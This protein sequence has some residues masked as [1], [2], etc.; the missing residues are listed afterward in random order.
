MMPG[1][2]TASDPRS[3]YT[4][5]RGCAYE[6]V[7]RGE[8]RDR[9]ISY[10]RLLVFVLGVVLAWAGFGA[11]YL[12]TGWVALPIATFIALMIWHEATLRRL[13]RSQRKEALYQRAL[14]R[15]H[16]EWCGKG[17]KGD[18]LQPVQHAY[19]ADLDLFG[20]GSL[21]ELICEAR[22]LSGEQTLARWFTEPAEYAT[23]AARQEAVCALRASVQLREDLQLAGDEM[24]SALAP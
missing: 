24:R 12:A 11:H 10:A 19:G 5:R 2:D 17:V 13:A 18:S 3:E 4:Q 8:R 9:H 15:L 7:R 23:I 22:T 14:Q 6:E 16:G 1:A 21:F 20:E